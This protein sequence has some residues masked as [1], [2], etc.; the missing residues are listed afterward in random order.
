MAVLCTYSAT[1]LAGQLPYVH[2]R[3]PELRREPTQRQL[4]AR[5]GDCQQ[6]KV[7]PKSCD[8]QYSNSELNLLVVAVKIA[9]T[10]SP[11]IVG[12]NAKNSGTSNINGHTIQFNQADGCKFL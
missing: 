3:Q 11:E 10:V 7:S 8:P 12:P 2:T 5:S 6:L 1:A 4:R 9:S